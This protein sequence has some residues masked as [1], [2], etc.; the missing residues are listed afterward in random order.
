MLGHRFLLQHGAALRGALQ[1][2]PASLHGFWQWAASKFESDDPDGSGESAG[3][4]GGE[5]RLSAKA[6]GLLEQIEKHGGNFF[7]LRIWNTGKE[8]LEDIEKWPSSK[9]MAIYDFLD[10]MEDLKPKGA[11]EWPAHR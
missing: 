1:R 10:L 11:P 7:V 8:R 9:V 6:R 2:H 3:S 4:P 5:R